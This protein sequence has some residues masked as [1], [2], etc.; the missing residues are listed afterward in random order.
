MFGIW[1][2]YKFNTAFVNIFSVMFWSVYM[3]LYLFVIDVCKY[4]FNSLIGDTLR[5][6]K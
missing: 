1:I 5:S 2:V 6:I 4:F 3:Y